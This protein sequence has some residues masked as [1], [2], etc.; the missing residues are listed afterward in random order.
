MQLI[1]TPPSSITICHLR[2][3]PT[4][5]CPVTELWQPGGV[6]Q[7]GP[8]ASVTL[9]PSVSGN[10]N[11]WMSSPLVMAVSSPFQQLLLPLIS[12]VPHPPPLISAYRGHDRPKHTRTR[13]RMAHRARF[14]QQ[15]EGNQFTL[16]SSPPDRSE[17]S[18]SCA[19][20][21]LVR[22]TRGSDPSKEGNRLL[23]D[24]PTLAL[25]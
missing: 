16:F 5:L 12:H 7:P 4:M 10:K 3:L 14:W 1:L 11:T 20:Q 13:H 17:S 6:L 22:M 23:G 25:K 18:S 19:P 21:H 2:L 15:S 8:P 24:S 9:A